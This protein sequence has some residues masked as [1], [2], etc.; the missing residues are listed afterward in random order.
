MQALYFIDVY[1]R[2]FGVEIEVPRI[3]NSF[4]GMHRLAIWSTEENHFR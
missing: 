3:P 2:I 4:I 1:I